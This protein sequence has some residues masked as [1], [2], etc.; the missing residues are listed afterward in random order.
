MSSDSLTL[1]LC[2]SETCRRHLHRLSH[3]SFLDRLRPYSGVQHL[4]CQLNPV[5]L[6]PFFSFSLRFRRRAQTLPRCLWRFCGGT[7]SLWFF[8]QA[9]S[10]LQLSPMPSHCTRS[11]LVRSFCNRTCLRKLRTSGQELRI[12]LAI[13]RNVSSPCRHERQAVSWIMCLVLPAVGESTWA[14]DCH[15]P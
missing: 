4:H 3:F 8:W 5:L 2:I 12:D 11:F 15:S 14:V 9:C 1:W 10:S 13:A 6:L 7:Y